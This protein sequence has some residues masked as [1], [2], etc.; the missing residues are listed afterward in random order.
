MHDPAPQVGDWSNAGQDTMAEPA[1][2]AVVW[3]GT[4]RCSMRLRPA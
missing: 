2:V 4:L 3:A 1:Q